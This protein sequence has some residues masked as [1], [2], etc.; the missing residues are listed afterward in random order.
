MQLSKTYCSADNFISPAVPHGWV[1][2]QCYAAY[3]HFV[4]IYNK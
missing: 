4:C 2:K 3:V 1:N